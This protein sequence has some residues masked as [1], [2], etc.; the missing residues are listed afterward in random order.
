MKE[1]QLRCKQFLDQP[2]NEN[3]IFYEINRVLEVDLVDISL[4]IQ[5]SLTDRMSI[6]VKVLFLLTTSLCSWANPIGTIGA[7]TRQ[8]SIQKLK[9]GSE[10]VA[11]Y[12][13]PAYV[14]P[15]YVLSLHGTSFQQGFDAGY[16]FGKQI[17]T[18]YNNL[19][20]SLFGDIPIEPVLQKVT[21]AFLDWQWDDYLSKQVPQE[22]MDELDG[23]KAGGVANGQV[24]PDLS[25]VT[26]R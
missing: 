18:N 23:L 11:L 21:E 17:I 4:K 8:E 3:P 2:I 10:L 7:V 16:L 6:A 9:S 19:F 12:S 13:E 14:D 20:R 1:L 25:K 5:T 22:Y 24:Y 15:I 26:S